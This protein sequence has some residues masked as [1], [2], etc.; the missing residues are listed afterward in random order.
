MTFRAIHEALYRFQQ[1]IEHNSDLNFF[2]SGVFLN[3]RPMSYW[4]KTKSFQTRMHSSRM[5]T[6][7][8]SSHPGGVPGPGG[9]PPGTPPPEQPPR[10]STPPVN[11]I[12]DTRL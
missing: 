1:E 10:T 9:S 5:R 12:L 8:S 11:R 2:S 4:A 3:C 7:R 6:A